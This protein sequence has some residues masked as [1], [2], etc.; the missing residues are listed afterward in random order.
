MALLGNLTG[1]SQFFNSTSFYNGV[2]TTSLRLDKAS[3]GYLYRTPSSGS[4]RRTFTIA[5]WYKTSLVFS[6]E[7]NDQNNPIFSADEPDGGGVFLFNVSSQGQGAASDTVNELQY[8][9]YDSGDTTDYGLE[10]NSSFSDPSSWY[11]IVWAF[12]TT[13]GTE[14]N[15]VK[16]YINGVQRAYTD[17]NQHHGAVVQ[18]RQLQ[19]ND[20]HPH[21]IGRNINT[22]SRYMN[23]YL[24]DFNFIDGTQYDASY[25]GEFK[26]GIWIPKEPSVTYGTNGFR[27][28]FKNTSV[29]SGSSS[30][31]GADTSGNNNHFTS[32]GIAASDCAMPDCPEN[33]FCTMTDITF[34]LAAKGTIAEGALKLPGTDHQVQTSTFAIPAS[35]K[36]YWE[37]NNITSDGSNHYAQYMGVMSSAIFHAEQDVSSYSGGNYVGEYIRRLAGVSWIAGNDNYYS[38]FNTTTISNGGNESGWGNQANSEGIL[39]LALDVDAGTLKYYW[40]NSLIRTDSTLT[41][42][43]EYFAHTNL[44]NSGGNFW[45]FATFNFGQDSSFAGAK[46]AAG[47]T[48]ANG[49]GDFYYAVPS[50]HLALCSANLPEPTIGPNSLTQADDHFNTLLWTGNNTDNRAITGLGFK[51]DLVI[52]K[53]RSGN[54]SPMLIDSSHPTSNGSTSGFVGTVNLLQ[55]NSTDGQTTSNGRSDGGFVSFDTDGFTLGQA[56]AQSGYP[57]AGYEAVNGGDDALHTYVGW[58]WKANGASSTTNDASAT[59]VGTIDSTFQA[60]TTAG[61]SIVKYEATGS[62]GTIKHGLSQAPN[63]MI[64]KSRDQAGTSWMV[65]YGDNTDYVRLEQN[66]ATIDGQSTWNDTTPTSSVFSV[67]VNGGDTNNS[68]GGSMV[69]YMFHAVDGYSKFGNFIG[70]GNADGTFVYTGFRPAWVLIKNTARSA[71]WRLHDAVRQHVNDGGGHIILLNVSTSEV[72]NEYDID[73]LSNGFKLRSGD[74]YENGSGELVIY[75]AFAEAPFKYANAR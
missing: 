57:N 16:V 7:G 38:N 40:N 9:D 72:T 48:D 35:G 27:L 29:G 42:N 2:V 50:G 23:G 4:N 73:F 64:V 10:T 11:H 66:G 54:T 69:G 22:T 20:A 32:S 5:F 59:G 3:S 62:A 49:N 52:I 71:D 74:V 51:P 63:F 24:A 44:T 12:D 61:F 36:W 33:N 67:G 8:Y 19:I 6:S 39:S 26:N 41:A 56:P 18:N 34:P 46:T 17:M 14:A 30:T 47:N 55:P 53:K 68:S 70:N 43:I 65:Y 15:R 25:F 13:Q 28:Q 37:V 75:A 60:N 58:S 31:I 21:W 1:S 45:S